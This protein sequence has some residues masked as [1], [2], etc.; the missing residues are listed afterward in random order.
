ML[1]YS[2]E[3]LT[4]YV[5]PG[6]ASFEHRW[7][8]VKT[9]LIVAKIES[10]ATKGLGHFGVQV[11]CDDMEHSKLLFHIMYNLPHREI[12]YTIIP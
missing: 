8:V 12:C 2:Y 3:T 7:G 10:L 1:C 4:R 9:V 5:L 6:L 11:G